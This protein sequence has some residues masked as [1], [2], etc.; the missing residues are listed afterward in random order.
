MRSQHLPFKPVMISKR[1]EPKFAKNIVI[2]WNC[3]RNMKG[4]LNHPCG[5]FSLVLSLNMAERY[6]KAIMLTMAYR[7]TDTANGWRQSTW[8]GTHCFSKTS[9]FKKNKTKKPQN[10]QIQNENRTKNLFFHPWASGFHSYSPHPAHHT[11]EYINHSFAFVCSWIHT[12]AKQPPWIKVYCDLIWRSECTKPGASKR[13]LKHVFLCLLCA[14]M[15]DICTNK[16]SGIRHT[17]FLTS[18]T[19]NVCPTLLY[20]SP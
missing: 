20:H 10:F 17:M 12:A 3:I 16:P 8:W 9:Q 5:M 14:C 15:C 6:F 2:K 19:E 13:V 7:F 4:H 18:V 11:P 1:T